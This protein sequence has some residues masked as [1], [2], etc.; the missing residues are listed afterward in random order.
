MALLEAIRIL[1]QSKL[2]LNN[3]VLFCFWGSEELSRIGQKGIGFGSRY[4]LHN[5]GYEKVIQ[6]LANKDSN[7]ELAGKPSLECYLNL[8][9]AGTKDRL[10]PEPINIG[11]P[12]E[13]FRPS[14][15]GTLNLT[16]LYAE[17]LDSQNMIYYNAE[18]GPSRTD[19]GSFYA[20][21]IPALTITAGPNPH[22]GCYHRSCDNITEVD[23]DVLSNITQTVLYALTKLSLGQGV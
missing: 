1:Q 17:F 18:P 8:E 12:R 19:V 3:P 10:F 5:K 13:Y 22:N 21:N 15:P 2:E 14:P 20:Q 7:Q 11:D 6:T 23:F 4:F 9:L 16:K